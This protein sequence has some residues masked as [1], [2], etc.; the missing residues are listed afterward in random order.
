MTHVIISL[1]NLAVLII[2]KLNNKSLNFLNGTLTILNFE[3]Y[4]RKI[5]GKVQRIFFL[6]NLFCELLLYFNPFEQ[7]QEKDLHGL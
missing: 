4:F 1:S 5:E 3:K 2:R 7:E 6:Q